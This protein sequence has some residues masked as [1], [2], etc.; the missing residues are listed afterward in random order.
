M[1]N[2]QEFPNR[3]GLSIK[4]LR[5]LPR[6]VFFAL[7]CA[8][9][10]AIAAFLGQIVLPSSKP[11]EPKVPP[12]R[13]SLLIDVSGSM[14]GAPLEEIKRASEKF[15][16]GRKQGDEIALT[17]F[18]TTAKL[19]T[20]MTSD[21]GKVI[22]EINGLTTSGGT[23]TDLG[24]DEALRQLDERSNLSSVSGVTKV[25]VL[26]TD[27]APDSMA[28]QP[29]IN[30][31]RA[32]ISKGIQVLAVGTGS[33]TATSLRQMTDDVFPAST[34]NVDSAFRKVEEKLAQSS[35]FTTAK[36]ATPGANA[37][38]PEL[39]SK[40]LPRVLLFGA[41]LALGASFA[42]VLANNIAM[43]SKREYLSTRDIIVALVGGVVAGA[44]GSFLAQLLFVTS[45]AGAF[46]RILGWTV[47]GAILGACVRF[48]VPNAPTLR[49]FLGG[50]IGGALGAGAFL[51]LAGASAGTALVFGAAILGFL[52]GIMIGIA[53]V[54][55]VGEAALIVHYGPNEATPPMGLGG[56]PIRL[57]S[58]SNSNIYL[59]GAPAFA[60]EIALRNGA[61]VF[62]DANGK[63]QNLN[64]RQRIR[65]G[66]LEIEVLASAARQGRPAA[67]AV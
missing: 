32:A 61:V 15:I 21:F 28:E 5:K 66:K 24:V 18:S 27:G 10:C 31:C 57:G 42:L 52:I 58:S 35:I 26:F 62:T 34:G 64:D 48:F 30:S 43:G 56:T 39:L 19:L 29:A 51:M 49:T 4:L 46:Q 13:I 11:A 14:S 17:E 65:V 33:A 63:S 44:A 25:L 3:G 53:I 60:G 45:G 55:T 50:A 37:P 38:K 67:A 22:Q 12:L 36:G 40:D 8:A 9:G 1:S 54:T 2:A 59:P 23:R 6:P 47:L 7:A 41:L 16:N 20:S